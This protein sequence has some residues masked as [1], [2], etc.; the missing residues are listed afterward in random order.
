MRKITEA[1][2]NVFNAMIES[3][4][5]RGGNLR[6]WAKM[7]R[8]SSSGVHDHL[9]LMEKKGLVKRVFQTHVFDGVT[10]WYPTVKGLETMMK[11]RLDNRCRIIAKENDGRTSSQ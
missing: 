6:V 7:L 9:I 10:G 3:P 2:R 5:G 8:M 1:Q 4:K 11:F